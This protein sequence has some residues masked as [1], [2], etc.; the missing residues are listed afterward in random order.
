MPKTSMAFLRDGAAK[1]LSEVGD[2]DREAGSV[3]GQV[4]CGPVS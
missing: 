3:V 2:F 4:K 1:A